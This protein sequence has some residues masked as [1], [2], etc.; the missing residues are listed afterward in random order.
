MTARPRDLGDRICSRGG[1]GQGPRLG[2][3]ACVNETTYN[4]CH[5]AA[6]VDPRTVTAMKLIRITRNLAP[7]PELRLSRG[8][9]RVFLEWATLRRWGKLPERE[10]SV[11]GYLLR[12][13]REGAGLTQRA[14]ASRLG[15]SQQAVAQAERWVSNPT[16][17][18]IRRWAAACGAKAT[19]RLS[20]IQ[21]RRL[22]GRSASMRGEIATSRRR[23]Q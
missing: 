17:D 14:L 4:L 22:S 11:V 2:R 20:R 13:A 3:L 15:V 21:A 9:P 23:R 5:G 10:Q 12:S 18:L 6:R 1:W 16:V 19:I 8:R 7:P